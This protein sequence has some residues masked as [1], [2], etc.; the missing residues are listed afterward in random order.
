[1]LFWYNLTNYYYFF[2]PLFTSHNAFFLSLFLAN[3]FDSYDFYDIG[4]SVERLKVILK[5]LKTPGTVGGGPDPRNPNPEDIL[6]LL[7]DGNPLKSEAEVKHDDS[8]FEGIWSKIPKAVNHKFLDDAVQIKDGNIFLKNWDTLKYT[9]YYSVSELSKKIIMNNLKIIPLDKSKYPDLYD[10]IAK[11]IHHNFIEGSVFTFVLQGLNSQYS[12]SEV[13]PNSFLVEI[14]KNLHSYISE[15]DRLLKAKQWYEH[16]YINKFKPEDLL[17][18][19][20]YKEAFELFQNRQIC[21]FNKDINSFNGEAYIPNML[22]PAEVYKELSENILYVQL[23][24]L[25][26]DWIIN[27]VKSKYSL[28]DLKNIKSNPELIKFYN[29]LYE[30]F[31]IDFKEKY[32]EYYQV[33]R[34]H[35]ISRID[36]Y[37]EKQCFELDKT[38]KLQSKNI[39]FHDKLNE[40]NIKLKYMANLHMSSD[41]IPG[42]TWSPIF[43]ISLGT[44]ALTVSAHLIKRILRWL[45]RIIGGG[46]GF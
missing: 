39:G 9:L 40:K 22:D 33:L 16:I 31:V 15:V 44:I 45:R 1:M 11:Y 38:L 8:W 24:I 30:D 26:S 27:K 12:V 18:Y 5:S 37:S 28:E 4:E 36:K 19:K 2:S 13:P 23:K 3:L 41:P 21:F 7:P 17:N 43:Y 10:Y 25:E 35:W 14:I 20:D 29:E 46:V 42:V 32:K 6:L 34:N